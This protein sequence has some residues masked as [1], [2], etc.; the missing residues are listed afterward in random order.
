MLTNVLPEQFRLRVFFRK[1]KKKT[2]I[3]R[4]FEPHTRLRRRAPTGAH[5]FNDYLPLSLSHFSLPPPRASIFLY[6]YHS[7]SITTSHSYSLIRTTRDAHRLTR[8]PQFLNR[9]PPSLTVRDGALTVF[10]IARHRQMKPFDPFR[11]PSH[12]LSANRPWTIGRAPSIVVGT[13]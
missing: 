12:F 9:I 10:F 1:Y 13:E 7:L 8:A 5:K 6:F 11:L 4:N 2:K 3:I